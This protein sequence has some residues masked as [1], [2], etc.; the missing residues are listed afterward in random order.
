MGRI[1]N[2]EGEAVAEVSMNVSD[3]ASLK[4]NDNVYIVPAAVAKMVTNM[5]DL[6]EKEQA[7][8]A[9]DA[10][11]MDKFIKGR[12]DCI[13]RYL[14]DANHW[15]YDNLKDNLLIGDPRN[16]YGD[17]DSDG[18]SVNG[19]FYQKVYERIEEALSGEMPDIPSAFERAKKG[20]RI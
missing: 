4:I 3:V 8:K 14:S 19:A 17:T 2:A 9:A 7:R 18:N 10:E 15:R 1:K 13:I 5:S 11:E 12:I 20:H 6:L 16:M